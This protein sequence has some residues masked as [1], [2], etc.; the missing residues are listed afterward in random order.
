VSTESYPVTQ[1]VAWLT[2]KPQRPYVIVA[3]F[4]GGEQSLCPSSQPHCSLYKEAMRSSADAI[5]VQRS[6]PWTRPEQ[7]LNLQG[8][9][10]RIPPQTYEQ[11]E[12]VLIRYKK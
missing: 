8:T 6:D 10:T 1:D 3:T 12:G 5:W 11:I 2:D 4:R 7:W 9:W